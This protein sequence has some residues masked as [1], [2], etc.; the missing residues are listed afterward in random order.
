VADGSKQHCTHVGS[1]ELFPLISRPGFLRV[2]QVHYCEADY[3]KCERFKRAL[4]GKSIPITLLPN[5]AELSGAPT[6]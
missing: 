6:T 2:W 5:G 1:C 4:A 3:A